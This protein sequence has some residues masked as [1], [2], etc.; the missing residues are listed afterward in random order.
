MPEIELTPMQYFILKILSSDKQNPIKGNILLQKIAFL[1]FQNFDVIF[2]EAYFIK[3]R[4]GPYSA[5]VDTI[6]KDLEYMQY[7][8]KVNNEYSITSKGLTEMSNYETSI[9]RKYI[10]ILDET[11]DFIKNDFKSF[12]SNEMLAFVYKEFPEYREQSIVDNE[13]DYENIFNAMYKSGKLGISK[14]A[15]LMGWS[16]DKTYDFLNQK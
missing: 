1:I 13:L 9:P 15:E 4:F 16:L 8:S 11:C 10:K 2:S 12:N 6:S 7:L 14:I 5:V 3:H